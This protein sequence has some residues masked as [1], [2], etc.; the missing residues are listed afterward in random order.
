MR[1][2]K[3]IFEL[4]SL[5][6]LIWSSDFLFVLMYD[7]GSIFSRVLFKTAVS[8]YYNKSSTSQLEKLYYTE[9]IVSK[10]LKTLEP[11]SCIELNIFGRLNCKFIVVKP[12]L[13]FPY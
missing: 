6:H 5:L 13:S 3:I 11:N 8:S 10:S 7:F 9:G 4:S 12:F 2:K 1:I